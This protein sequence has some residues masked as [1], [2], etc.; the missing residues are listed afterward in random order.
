MSDARGAVLK[1][2]FCMNQ[3]NYIEL[4]TIRA[5]STIIDATSTVITST[6]TVPFFLF[7]FVC[8]IL[9]LT[10]FIILLWVLNKKFV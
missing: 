4:I 8:A 6:Q 2:F 9:V 3:F 5:T 7:T 1:R 10:L